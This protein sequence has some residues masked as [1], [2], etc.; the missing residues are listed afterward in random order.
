MD[1]HR[2]NCLSLLL[3][4][5]TIPGISSPSA[6]HTFTSHT[7][8]RSTEREHATLHTSATHTFRDHS[9]YR[10]KDMRG[11]CTFRSATHTFARIT[12]Y[13]TTGRGHFIAEPFATHT[14]TSHTVYRN[15]EKGHATLH[16][17]CDTHFSRQFHVSR[18]R[19]ARG[20]R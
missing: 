6:T 11:N 10:G 15:T 3:L 17:T 5:P 14:F 13:R 18:G 8:Y 4:M 19:K 1:P 7:V 12:L 16:T 9:V 20:R 2:C